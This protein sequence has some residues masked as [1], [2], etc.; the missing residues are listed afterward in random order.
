MSLLSLTKEHAALNGAVI[1]HM[2]PY[3]ALAVDLAIGQIAPGGQV[4]AVQAVFVMCD[5]L[6]V[7][8]TFADDLPIDAR[9]IQ[10]YWSMRSG[11]P[12][13]DWP[14]FCRALSSAAVDAWWSAYEATRDTTGTVD[15]PD[16]ADTDPNA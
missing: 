7:D 4:D 1:F 12:A 13:K 16:D 3:R 8:I 15:I 9:T 6:T 2:L 14:L 11:D 5:A 10:A